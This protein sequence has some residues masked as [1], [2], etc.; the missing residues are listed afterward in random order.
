MVIPYLQSRVDGLEKVIISL[1]AK[2]MSL[3]DIEEKIRGVI[4]LLHLPQPFFR[5]IETVAND[6]ITWQNRP[7]A[8][9]YLIV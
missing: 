3:S 5:F 2:G 6:I 7:L 1:Y 9:V 8:P 4:I